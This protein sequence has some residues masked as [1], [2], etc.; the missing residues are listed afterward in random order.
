MTMLTTEI[1]KEKQ[2]KA[3]KKKQILSDL[4]ESVKFVKLHQR[5]KLK[6]KLIEDLLNEL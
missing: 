4:E 2:T 5:G 3:L 6:A 1:P